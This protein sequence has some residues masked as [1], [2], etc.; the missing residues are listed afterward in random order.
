MDFQV[1]ALGP[2]RK[3]VAVTV[4]AQRV[5]EAFDK[6]YEEISDKVPLRGFRQGRAPRKLLE[7]RFGPHLGDEVKQDLVKAALEELFDSKQIEPLAPPDIDVEALALT[8]GEELRFEFEI[9]T[10][11]EFET[12]AWKGLEVRVPV[13][14]ASE[15]EID[16]FV[17]TLRRSGAKLADAPD[18][19]VGDGDLL[20]MDW[21][22]SSG[23]SVEA[24]DDGVYY[25]FGR[26]VL[27]GFVAEGLDEQLR[28]A[29]AGATATAKVQVAADDPRAE[30]RGKELDLVATLKE[31]KRYELPPLD[32]EFLSK[33]DYDN[34]EELREDMKRRI[35]R[36]KGRGRDV[37][38]ERKLVEQLLGSIEISLP[39]GFVDQEL[40]HWA[41]RKRISL[42]ME[43]VEA[44]E[45]EKQIAEGRSDTRTAIEQDMR[46]YFLL[47]RI[48][49]EEN[50]EVTEAEL[51]AA[52]EE[53]A[54]AYG[55]P[56]EQVMQSFRDS[57]RLAELQGEIRQRKARELVRQNAKLVED[58]ALNEA[59]QGASEDAGGGAGKTAPKKKAKK[60]D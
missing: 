46:R 5:G 27:A 40:E 31:V 8:P 47:N 28:G 59:A 1:Q 12:P 22:A 54:Q 6:K 51:V 14:E 48:A 38:A 25:R 18:G 24:R 49:K 60:K 15:Q 52:I 39:D 55:H 3:K 20:V 11:P 19:V 44:E 50:I 53:V 2:C 45:I 56:V 37:E 26:G 58:A 13:L 32:A 43:K 57:R 9:V 41:A 36:A 35:L 4:P 33:H 17:D 21:V 30:L 29:K 16:G 7:K 42:Q 10:Q 23:D 34:E